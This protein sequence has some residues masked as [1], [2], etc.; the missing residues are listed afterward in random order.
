MKTDLHPRYADSP[1][2]RDAKALISA[3]VHCGFCN[4]T[5]PTYQEQKDERDGPRGRIYLI[6]RMLEHGDVTASSRTHLDR[7]LT[8]RSCE[9]TCPSGV[10][11]G[12]IIDAGRELVEQEKG[13]RGRVS[14]TLRLVLRKIVPYPSRFTPLLRLGQTFGFL[15]PGPM[16]RKIPEKQRVP[17]WP[18]ARW[19]RKM[20]VLRGCVQSGATPRTNA[21]AA[22]VLDSLG[23]SLTEAA[24]AGCC[25]SASQHLSAPDDALAFAKR[26]IDAWWPEVEAGAEAIVMTAS[27]CGN[28]VK[29]YG[30]LLRHDADYA[31]KAARISEMTLDLSEVLLAEGLE[32]L[33]RLSRSTRIAAHCPCSLQHAQKQPDAIE[34]IMRAIG[35]EL[36]PTTE[37]HLCCGSAGTY[38]ILQPELSQRLLLR[39]V[40][41]LTGGKPDAIVTGNV[42]CQLHLATKADVPVKHWIEVVLDACRGE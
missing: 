38:S 39:K 18:E 12:K 11:Y 3:C 41:A 33:P 22:L 8:C 20:L 35:V 16:G 32:R 29:D 14:K 13:S 15:I 27:G 6:R 4:A 42:G 5:C 24:K 19:A 21:A 31:H 25:G 36:T 10:Q 40:A 2:A 1:I 30:H 7:C 28:M 34:K 23:I 9:T 26:N 17:D 37:K